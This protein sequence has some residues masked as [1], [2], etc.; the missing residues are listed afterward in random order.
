MSVNSSTLRTGDLDWLQGESVSTDPVI[1]QVPTEA[2]RPLPV[3]GR[4]AVA[5]LPAPMTRLVGREA[6]LDA[7]LAMFRDPSIRL[8]TLTGPGGVGKTRLAL[9]MANL[10]GER[11]PDR[12]VFIP[13]AALTDPDLVLPTIAA[14]LGVVAGG[15]ALRR[16][17]DA[18]L[19]G[20]NHLLLLDNFEH[21][22][23]AGGGLASCSVGPR[24]SGCWPP[25]GWCSG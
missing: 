23:E 5:A 8:V 13:L 19:S 22:A 11:L 3:S 24:S 2:I 21:V 20:R 1:R 4:V 14:A 15:Q 9:Q 18:S 6:D 25:R 16:A 7:L 10:L 12:V 17:L